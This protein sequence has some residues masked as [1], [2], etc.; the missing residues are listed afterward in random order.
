MQIPSLLWE[1]MDFSVSG[2]YEAVTFVWKLRLVKNNYIV[3]LLILKT[4]ILF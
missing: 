4:S 2:T 3:N 1:M